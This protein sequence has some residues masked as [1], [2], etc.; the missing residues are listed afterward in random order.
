M[1]YS[2]RC[3]GE[4][5][6]RECDGGGIGLAYAA[7]PEGPWRKH[8]VPVISRA[9]GGVPAYVASVVRAQGLYHLY[10]ENETA[11]DMGTLV[12]WTALEPEGPWLLSPTPALLPGPP[13]AWDF[14][15]FSESRVN[16]IDGV[17]HLFYSSAAQ[18]AADGRRRLGHD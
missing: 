18:H 1:L 11:A 8:P 17:F 16:Y 15:G 13:G 7:A 3:G 9:Q 14:A 2:A 6:K 4:F 5:G 10:C 12:H